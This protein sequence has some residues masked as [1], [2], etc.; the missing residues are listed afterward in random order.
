MLFWLFGTETDSFLINF[1]YSSALSCIS[2]L[3]FCIRKKNLWFLILIRVF[4][5]FIIWFVSNTKIILCWLLISNQVL[6]NNITMNLS[7]LCAV[8]GCIDLV[9]SVT[10]VISL[11]MLGLRILIYFNFW[12]LLIFYIVLYGLYSL[13]SRAQRRLIRRS[14][15][16]LLISRW[17]WISLRG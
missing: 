14:F 3:I 15:K 17:S 5:L 13:S 9:L 16:A 8:P 6:R 10:I 1:R 7:N 2:G 11:N 12:L 4:S